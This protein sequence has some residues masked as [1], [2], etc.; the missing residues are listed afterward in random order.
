MNGDMSQG[1]A[2]E[3]AWALW[4]R[5]K[6]LSIII[7]GV[8]FSAVVGIVLFLPNIYKSTATVLV[9]RDHAPETFAR[10]TA[11]VEVDTRL[12]AISEQILSRSRLQNLVSL[13]NLYPEMRKR[14][15]LEEVVERMRRDIRLE[16]KGA[17]RLGGPSA[18]VA[19]ALSYQGRDPKTV[20]LVANTLASFYIE[21]NWKARGR[22]ATETAEFFKIQLDEM[23]KRLDE[24]GRKVSEFKTRHPGDN[25][26]QA[27]ANLAALDR[28]NMQ[29]R[30]NM[31]RL[32]RVMERR[33]TL[34]KQL[35]DALPYGS[36][37][38]PGPNAERIGKL[39][40]ELRELRTRYSDQYPDVIRLKTEIAALERGDHAEAR[41]D[42][43]V[44]RLKQ[45][46]NEVEAE[47]QGIKEEDGRLQKA[48][49][50]YYRKIEGAQAEAPEVPELLRNYEATKDLYSSLLKRYA[51]AQHAES[52]EVRQ[53]GEM[54]RIL[55]PAVPA[56]H[57]SAPNRFRLIL[58]GLVLSLGAAVFAA[59][60]ADQMDTTF[61]TVDDLRAFT[62][63]PVL[64]SIPYIATEADGIR[65]RQRIRLAAV[66]AVLGLALIIGFS[67]Y[68]AHENEGIVKMVSR[69]PRS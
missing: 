2:F 43:A 11:G 21:E 29:L 51:D 22:Q 50:A 38:S 54:F 37:G 66:A 14:S 36:L 42:P 26:Q 35:G 52:W 64:V 47:I 59:V 27:Q 62:K 40:Q 30:V 32:T 17:E 10:P 46:L 49:A 25:P 53:K 41:S 23:R 44:P 39:R 4:E 13:Y 9:E 12:R 3:L 56:N 28:L 8:L 6:W 57:P 5:R 34:A 33:E 16:L 24:Q 7:F 31:E 55:D 15:P 18:T 1:S 67:Y 58:M 45:A 61:H 65:K 68:V 48:M 20:S 63:V 69:G 60:L 19:F